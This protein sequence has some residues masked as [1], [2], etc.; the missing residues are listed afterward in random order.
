MSRR[1]SSPSPGPPRQSRQATI[2]RLAALSCQPAS[3]PANHVRSTSAVDAPRRTL[4]VNAGW[5][6]HHLEET[7]SLTGVAGFS[8]SIH[9]RSRSGTIEETIALQAAIAK[10]TRRTDPASRADAE[11]RNQPGA[12]RL[13]AGNWSASP[14]PRRLVSAMFGPVDNPRAPRPAA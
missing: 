9:V 8:G 12:A 2:F 11:V 6:N 3:P 4:R 14:A 5:A 7:S 1:A 13:R 10:S